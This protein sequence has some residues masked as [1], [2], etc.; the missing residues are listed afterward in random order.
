MRIEKGTFV[1]VRGPPGVY[2]GRLSYEKGGDAELLDCFC[3]WKYS[4]A[5]CINQLAEEGVNK[6]SECKFSQ[7]VPIMYLK[8]IFQII[9]C[10]KRAELI[11]TAVNRWKV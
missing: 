10:S 4:G 8:Q 5:A 6:P 1:I 11:L 3:L 9:P 7:S 2:A